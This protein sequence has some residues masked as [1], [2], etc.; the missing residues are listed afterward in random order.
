LKD[1]LIVLVCLSSLFCFQNETKSKFIHLNE[2]LNVLSSNNKFMGRLELSKNGVSIYSKSI[3]FSDK[4]GTILDDNSKFVIG[5][6]SKTITSIL[7]LKSI[8]EGKL[9]LDTKLSSFY[10]EIINS[11]KIR[12]NDLLHHRSGIGDFTLSFVF[13]DKKARL[14]TRSEIFSLIK[15]TKTEFEPNSKSQYSSTNYI[16][17]S[18]ILEKIYNES[19]SKILD[20]KLVNPLKLKHTF[21]PKGLNEIKTKSFIRTYDWEVQQDTHPS[22]PIGAGAVVS[23]TTDLNTILFNLFNGKIINKKL[24]E[25]MITIKD[26]F[27]KGIFKLPI[28]SK[29]FDDDVY[30][31][32]GKIDG[33]N[34]YMAYF[35]NSNIAISITSNGENYRKLDIIQFAIRTFLNLS[36]KMPIFSRLKI[37]DDILKGYSGVYSSK[38]LN[39]IFELKSKMNTLYGGIKDQN[40]FVFDAENSMLF[41]SD[42]AEL[43]LKFTDDRDSMI[44]IHSGKEYMFNKL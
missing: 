4:K 31:H 12:I 27:G 34:T 29:E 1:L 16:V 6:C 38:E 15:S 11:E 26:G 22:F 17:L 18:M 30:G 35:K 28:L 13:S 7:I 36:T 40:V 21:L 37:S 8:D 24:V 10:P 3:G 14:F 43:K 33:F 5:S 25:K 9:K 42:E 44:I 19:Y 39:M 20:T 2:Y 41:N 23:T 32:S